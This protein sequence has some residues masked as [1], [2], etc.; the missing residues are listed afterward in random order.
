MARA[1][2]AHSGS[3]TPT[4]MAD[5]D[6]SNARLAPSATRPGRAGRAGLNLAVRSGDN[7][8]TPSTARGM[9]PRGRSFDLGTDVA[10]HLPLAHFGPGDQLAEHVHVAPHLDRPIE[11]EA[12]PARVLAKANGQRAIAVT[13]QDAIGQLA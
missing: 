10:D 8:E 7:L 13:L 5:S 4:P 1:I 9:T 6:T 11:H 3:D 12:R 2:A